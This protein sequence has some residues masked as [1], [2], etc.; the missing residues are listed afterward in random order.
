[1]KHKISKL[2]SLYPLPTVLVGTVINGQPN[3]ITMAYVGVLVS[4]IVCMGMG[5]VHYSGQGIKE[6]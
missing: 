1:M 4:N 2:N 3:Y 5:K 6:N